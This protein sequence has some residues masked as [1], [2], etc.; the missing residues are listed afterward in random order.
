MRIKLKTLLFIPVICLIVCNCDT[1]EQS[2]NSIEG[3]YKGT[4]SITYNVFADNQYSLQGPVNFQFTKNT[5][6][7][8]G[9]KQWLPPSG[10]GRY[11]YDPG[12][13]TLTDTVGHSAD[14]DWTLI[15][16]GK[17]FIISNGNHLLLI[18]YDLRY[19]RKHE[20]ELDKQE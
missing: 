7:C 18:R 2:S 9:K 20:I 16:N 12:F 11:S 13:I 1:V 3:V 10:V 5:Y 14:F 17:F 4:Y 19:N 6:R 8:E 15:L